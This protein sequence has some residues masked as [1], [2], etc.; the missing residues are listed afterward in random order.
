[1]KDIFNS[2]HYDIMDPSNTMEVRSILD[3]FSDSCER[4]GPENIS[5]H[6]IFTLCRLLAHDDSDISFFSQKSLTYIGRKAL[7][8]LIRRLDEGTPEIKLR[9]ASVLTDMTLNYDE[10]INVAIQIGI[11]EEFDLK[12]ESVNILDNAGYRS[13]PAIDL[14]LDYTTYGDDQLNR[15]SIRATA[16]NIL[17][18]IGSDA[19]SRSVPVLSKILLESRDFDSIE[20]AARSLIMIGVASIP[21]FLQG[22]EHSDGL[23][24]NNSVHG[25]G[26]IGFYSDEIYG[27][28]KKLKKD[29]DQEVRL[30]VRLA[31]HRLGIAKNQASE[32]TP[33]LQDAIDTITSND[34]DSMLMLAKPALIS[35]LRKMGY[36]SEDYKQKLLK[37]MFHCDPKTEDDAILE[38]AKALADSPD[39]TGLI[40]SALIKYTQLHD[41]SPMMRESIFLA[42]DKLQGKLQLTK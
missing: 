35:D 17:G 7:P 41:I 10:C 12:L 16:A 32:I 14:I 22:L 1:M 29:K 24:R 8:H 31:L 26:A 25:L 9:V 21:T 42:S 11:P 3:K 15:V 20:S 4:F 6:H 13:Y 36:R 39:Q 5:D 37:T 18:Y 2:Q 33:F 34:R 27:I 30:Q 40:A 23:V 38:A 19:S 28:I